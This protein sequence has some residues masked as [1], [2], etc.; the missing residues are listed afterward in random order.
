MMKK[1]NF[2]IL[3]IIIVFLSTFIVWSQ[4]NSSYNDNKIRIENEPLGF[5][6]LNGGMTGGAGGDTIVV[7][8]IQKLAD[9]FKP[10]EKNLTDPLVIFISGTLSVYEDMFDIK[11]EVFNIACKK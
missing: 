1:V 7:T 8:N 10:R 5:A 2:I 6:S 11:L 4:V 9:T 3:T